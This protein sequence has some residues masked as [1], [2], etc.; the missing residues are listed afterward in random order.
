MKILLADDHP[1][2]RVGMRQIVLDEFPD[3]QIAEA[4][5]AQQAIEMVTRDHWNLIILDLEMPGGGGLEVLRQIKGMRAELPVLVLSMHKESEYGPLVLREGASGYITKNAASTVL[6][7]AIH[8]VLAG[9]KYVSPALA[10]KLAFEIEKDSAK[11]PHK[12]LSTREYQVFLMLA[13]GQTVPQ[14]AKELSLSQ[15]TVRVFRS[16]LLAKMGMQ[17]NVELARYAIEHGLL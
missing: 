16:H 13:A 9:G 4:L 2:I 15:K 7:G 12:T 17:N 8:K 6:A 5:S 10:E 14:I 3:A 11:P 1:L